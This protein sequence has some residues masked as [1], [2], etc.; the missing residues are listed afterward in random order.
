MPIIENILHPTDFSEGSMIAFNHAL[1]LALLARSGMTL[2]H[3]SPDADS[4]SWSDFPGVRETLERWQ[5]LP[6]GSPRSAVPELGIG[7]RK[8]IA[9]NSDPVKAVIGFL[10]RHPVQLI[11]LATHQRR[12]AIP[13]LSSSVAEPIARHA[14]EMTLFISGDSEGFVSG[15]DGSA[16]L[17]N[18]LIPIAMTPHPQTAVDAA[19]GLV[20]SLGC[21]QG[22]FTLVHVGSPDSVP[23]VRLP[24]VPGWTWIRDVLEGDVVQT[25]VDASKDY[26]ADLVVMA[27][28]GRNGFLDALRGSNSERV[29]RL[30]DMPI[31]TVPVGSTVHNFIR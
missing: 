26:D 18:V 20:Q 22:T 19:A 10:D 28:D 9:Q 23:A 3:V 30:A 24:N 4:S 14:T 17:I 6:A 1:K 8:T 29:L 15:D 25:I 12:G 21:D 2:L 13:W 5:L 31:L 27:T 7:V 16:S 11:V